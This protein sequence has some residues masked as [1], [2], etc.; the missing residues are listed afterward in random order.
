MGIAALAAE[1]ERLRR[2]AEDAERAL[3]AEREALAAERAMAADQKRLVD[4]Q[5]MQL[6]EAN[7]KLEALAAANEDLA[8]KLELLEL[9]RNGRKNERFVEDP[10]QI[11]LLTTAS[12][13]A[14]PPRLP[15]N[16]AEEEPTPEE[17]Q[18]ARRERRKKGGGPRRR[19]LSEMTELPLRVVRCPM[20]PAAV[21]VECKGPLKV[22]GQA[23][24]WRLHWVP[25]HFERLQVLK[26][27]CA[28]PKCDQQ[29]VLTVPD[30]FILPRALCSNGLLA[31]VLV[32]KFADHLPLNR[33]AKRMERQGVPIS[34]AVLS[35]WVFAVAHPSKGMLS[36]IAAAILAELFK[37]A[38]LRADDTGLPV[39]DG[40]DGKLRKGRLWAITDGRQAS[41]HFTDDKAGHRIA[42]ILKGYPGK[43]ILVDGGSE[44]NQVVRMLELERAGCWSH[45]RRYLFD[46]RDHHPNEAALALRTIRDLFALE[47]S[48]DGAPLERIREVRQQDARPLV[49]GLF[50]WIDQLST[51]VRPTSAL[52]E[53][54]G[55]A[56]NQRD[57]FF[58]YLD[59]PE[60][61]MHNNLSELLLRGPVVG[62]KNWMFAGS[63]GGAEAAAVMFTLIASCMLQAIDPLVYL[64]D[65]LD[66]LPFHP[67]NRVHELTPL[68]WR[69]ARARA[70]GASPDPG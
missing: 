4:L 61:P 68:E 14:P 22:I 65:V 63:E 10:A 66:R 49:E 36:R 56:R 15:G 17:A 26:D 1:V 32:D 9:K 18:E 43:L 62:R 70:T 59:H 44:F 52:G 54:I 21:C 20:D 5:A 45:L 31:A 29:G 53:A 35:A 7:Q 12:D 11:S 28:C 47:R 25:G 40:V 50:T 38:A 8:R 3:A 69:L 13:L 30:P 19:N 37:A 34:T 42:A 24:A 48:L 46:A 41:I 16:E 57:T 2:L 33:Q 67:A 27:K 39:Q 58:V 60:L 6:V 23:E 55:Y 64:T 51:T